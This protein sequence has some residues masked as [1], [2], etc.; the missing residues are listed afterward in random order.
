MRFGLT[1]GAE[2]VLMSVRFPMMPPLLSRLA[3]VVAV[4]LAVALPCAAQSSVVTG[5]VTDSTAAGLPG[6]TVVLLQP[7]DSTI[8]SFG[9]SRT[10]GTFRIPRVPQGAFLLQVTYVGYVPSTAPVEVG[11]EPVDVG[12]I[13]LEVDLDGLDPL[14]VT[15]NRG[16]M[17]IKRDT[18]EFNAA[19]FGTPDGASVEDLLRRLPG[20]Q[21]DRDGSIEA[22]G[23]EVDRVLVDGREFFGDDPTIATRNLP[24]DAVD[25][26]QIYDR[27]SE[28]A[29]FTGV[30]DGNEERTINLA[31]REDRRTGMFGNVGGGFGGSSV[32]PD[33][34]LADGARFDG[35]ASVNRFS[36][37][38][39]MS[40]LGNANN[41]NRQDF[42]LDDY[43]QF[44]GGFSALASGGGAIR[45]NS[46]DIGIP[47]GNGPSDGFTTT[48]A[49]GLNL[50]H[51]FS[52]STSL[53]SNYFGSGIGTDRQR[54]LRRQQLLG[55]DLSAQ[56]TE[57]DQTSSQ[58][59]VHRLN[60]DLLH[61]IG[62]GHD[63]RLRSNV[64]SLG[65]DL[66]STS[67]RETVGPDGLLEADR[68]TTS[69][70]N[71]HQP[72]GNAALTYR[73]RLPGGRSLVGLARADLSLA[74][75]E[76]DLVATNRESG[77]LE[78]IDQFRDQQGTTFTRS[79]SLLFT[80]PITRR[81]AL[82]L[83]VGHTI[84]SE[85]EDRAV[86]DRLTGT[87]VL[88]DALSS[89]FE[90]T[91]HTTQGGF[92]FRDNGETHQLSLGATLQRTQLDGE[93]L[94]QNAA[95]ARTSLHV[96]PSASLRYTFPRDQ[97]LTLRYT[98]STT[99]PT[100]RQLQPV[101]DNANPLTIYTGNPDLQPAFQ[102]TLS[103]RFIHFDTFS[104]TNVSSSVRATYSPTAI[105]TAR[106]VD[107][108]FRQTRTPINTSGTW[109][110]TGNAAYGTPIRPIRTRISLS[111]STQYRRQLEQ[112]NGAENAADLFRTTVDLGVENQRK[113][114][115][116]VRAG[117]R[118]TFNTSTYSL[119]PEFNQRYVTPTLYAEASTELGASWFIR[120]SLD[121]E[122]TPA[123]VFGSARNVP[124]WSAEI[125]KRISDRVR[126]QL[127]GG[128]LLDQGIG[129]Q[130]ASSGGVIQ[131]E[132]VRSLGR[133]ILLKLV[134][135]L[136]EVRN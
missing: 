10:D 119:S 76:R 49:G 122:R 11:A 103:A 29:E 8:V 27:D 9:A 109:T 77:G 7:N 97:S 84:E 134:Y 125:S 73:K 25:R 24:A 106:T 68:L 90:R 100:L 136:S 37:S 32:P 104:L 71:G 69:G 51:E 64:R 57:A 117:G 101:A 92:I 35:S 83:N 91:T 15:A 59:Q 52:S 55:T 34:G 130:Y 41:V 63:V 54:D 50:N 70:T 12:R 113:T 2:S 13:Q 131:E 107:D 30:A 44:L 74:S 78:P 110:V 43:I 17:V 128:D 127:V 48:F 132:R 16:A 39:Q 94:D 79:S 95:V 31:L 58:T 20:V 6:A 115:F 89:A 46:A 112:V 85:D 4:A 62:E 72:G 87:P 82:Q 96:L 116:D 47:L 126:V 60:L 28:T 120:S 3:L 93:I 108:Q 14:V 65:T 19:A 111:A 22:Q 33:G 133:H 38:T 80:Q 23:E 67:Q 114:R 102:H 42:G 99:E 88:D 86:M 36:P 66:A 40:F 105:S 75:E 81:R 26:V 121:V 56:T 1:L 21:V 129:I 61:E 124:L 53:Q 18:L 123:D 135:N 45:I 5:V 98:A 118:V